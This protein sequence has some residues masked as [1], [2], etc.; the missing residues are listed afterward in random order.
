MERK[1]GFFYHPVFLAHVAGEM[2]AERPERL[3]AVLE[4]LGTRDF[5][6]QAEL[7]EP[8]A[9]READLLLC[10]TGAHV[11][12]V[13]QACA[14]SLNVDPDT[15]TCPESW[16]AALIA[17]G[18]G[19]QAADEVAAARFGRAFC[20]VRPPGHHAGSRSMGFCLFN[21]IAI[22]AKHLRERLSLNRVAIVDFDAHHGNGTQEI[23]Y[24]DADV[25]YSSVHQYPFYPGTGIPQ[26]RGEGPGEG[27]NLNCPLPAGTGRDGYEAA[28]K[29]KILPALERFEPEILLVSAGFDAHRDDPL[30][31]MELTDR[32]FHAITTW[33]CEFA[34]RFCRGRIISMLEG[35]Y[36]LDALAAS[37]TAHFQ[38][39]AE[40]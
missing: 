8:R 30:T 12:L 15:G 3:R 27:A 4:A 24:R 26:E 2:H 40:T 5:W 29:E 14:S 22:T 9:A 38:A 20:L 25:H 36:D 33:L 23:F 21:S 13:K 17:V 16:L 35:G 1:V 7:R 10:H 18:A 11:S 37:V 6:A 34:N 31:D 19:L 39:L 28:F 32:D